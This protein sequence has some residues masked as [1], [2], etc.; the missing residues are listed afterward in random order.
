MKTS[1]PLDRKTTFREFVQ[2]M[3]LKNRDELEAYHQNPYTSE[4][5]FHKYKWWLRIVYRESK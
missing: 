5:Y 4:Q 1:L 3:W 2:E